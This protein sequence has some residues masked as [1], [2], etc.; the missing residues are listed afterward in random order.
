MAQ[1]QRE[2]VFI[3]IESELRE[4][5]EWFIRLR[6][7]AGTGILIGTWLTDTF[8]SQFDLAPGP[9][10]LIGATVLLYNLAF[11]LLRTR[12][13]R[14]LKL[15]KRS[16]IVQI[17][18]DWI[19]LICLVH[20]SGGVWSPVSLAFVFHI[21]I[22]A[23]LLSR[24][25]CYLLSGFAALL[26][27]VLA[28]VEETGIWPP[29][30]YLETYLKPSQVEIS[31][32]YLWAALAVIFLVTAF[33][34]T[35][36][37]A[38]LREKE[39]ALSS[40]EQAL[41]R[42][43]EEMAALYQLGQVVNSTLDFKET[44]SLIAEHTTKLMNMKAC[45]IRL[46]DDSGKNLYVGGS[47]GLSEDYL[48]KGPVEIEKSLID[49]ETLAGG[50]VQVLEVAEDPRF[51]YR[52]EAKRE[53]IRSALCV[54]ISVGNRILGVIRVYSKQPHHFRNREQ[55][56]LLNM[57]NLG[58]TA[59]ENARS[60]SDLQFL[61]EQ[62]VWFAR[63]THHQLR[64]PLSAI[65]AML[66]ALPYAGDLNAKQNELIERG[67]RRVQ[68]SF[69]IIR[70]LLDLAAA[71][72]PVR[73][74]KPVTVKLRQAL[75]KAVESARE[76]AKV[77]GVHFAIE[78]PGSEVTVQAQAADIDRIFSNLLDNSVKYTPT[79]GNVSFSILIKDE[80][81][82][83]RV[84]DNGI[85]IPEAE[86]ERVFEGFFRTKEAKAT[87]EIGTGLGL[88]IVKR[89]IERWKW[90]LKLESQPGK[91]TTFVVTI[92]EFKE[93]THYEQPIEPRAE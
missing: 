2:R 56:L 11:Y 22:G 72:R 75:E 62:R 23:I 85:G 35:S 51:Q 81:L 43:Y 84:Q 89:L 80:A 73:A 83:A 48:N 68:D 60:Y 38:R 33:L 29:A 31:G 61:N 76:R 92:P 45:F 28:L 27:G 36:I 16:L 19:V 82:I 12:S 47:Y 20:Y 86:H 30:L 87:G 69:D 32:F 14:R 78:L 71:Q 8:A 52:E 54:P 13:K 15:L 88:S 40:S 93:L 41:K 25:A 3:P 58:A 9:L 7:M 44:L 65:R 17:A 37:T 10:Y 70:D 74:Q 1:P 79:G 26:L 55:H 64:T 46:F 42:A 77:K 67:C 90:E 66:D 5:L 91:G 39:E 59:I 34:V 4:R 63:T 6:W 24:K 49:K 57:A 18:L 53:G 50:A 21:I